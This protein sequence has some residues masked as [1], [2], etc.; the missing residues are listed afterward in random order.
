[1][2]DGRARI[3]S[4]AP[5]E[6]QLVNLLVHFSLLLLINTRIASFKAVVSYR[7]QSSMIFFRGASTLSPHTSDRNPRLGPSKDAENCVFIDHLDFG[8]ADEQ[9]TEAAEPKSGTTWFLDSVVSSRSDPPIHVRLIYQV[10]YCVCGEYLLILD[11][12]IEICPKRKTDGAHILV[13]ADRRYK[14]SC[15][16]PKTKLIRRKDGYEKQYRYSCPRCLLPFLYETDSEKRRSGAFSYI[17]HGSLRDDRGR[18]P[19]EL[20]ANTI[21]LH[22]SDEGR[23]ALQRAKAAMM[24]G[25]S[26][27][28][29]FEVLDEEDEEDEREEDGMEGVRWQKED[30][31]RGVT[32]LDYK[33]GFQGFGRTH[34]LE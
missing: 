11:R 7:S 24:A 2:I 3:G 1:V 27:D 10:Y 30:L 14:V 18:D 33:V 34:R 5:R 16:G 12:R 4:S 17:L 6:T 23:A 15:V 26:L 19:D 32:V 22:L 29:E 31:G 20:D 28:D 13:N 8:R 9:R 25:A 21:N